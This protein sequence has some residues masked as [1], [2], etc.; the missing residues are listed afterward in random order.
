MIRASKGLVKLN[1]IISMYNFP[2][3]FIVKAVLDRQNDL[4][5]KKGFPA[6]EKQ[7]L[8]SMF[9]QS[10]RVEGRL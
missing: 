7:R 1:I 4:K 2:M 8:S 10:S 9:D 3:K 5:N 6:K